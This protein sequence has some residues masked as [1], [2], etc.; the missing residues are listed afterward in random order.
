MTLLLTEV[1]TNRIYL[2]IA[3][4]FLAGF[5]IAILNKLGVVT[6]FFKKKVSIN[7]QQNL[8]AKAKSIES[9][10]DAVI[11]INYD[12]IIMAWNRG[13]EI[14]FGYKELDALNK[15]F[16]III[17]DRNK[18][19]FNEEFKKM[20]EGNSNMLGRNVETTVIG[21]EK[22]EFLVDILMWLWTDDN[23]VFYSALINNERIEEHEKNERKLKIY[24]IGEEIDNSGVWHW[25]VLSDN[26]YYSK[27]FLDI[28]DVEGMSSNSV[29]LLKKVYY[30]DRASVEEAIRKAFETKQP[31]EIQYRILTSNGKIKYLNCKAK[32]YLD[33]DGALQYI[34]GVIHEL[35]T[36]LHNY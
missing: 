1:I 22:T 12:G 15:P 35:R 36:E 7:D 2:I 31:Y 25:D 17:P 27:G 23:K 20:K 21:R 9:A 3:F 19:N 5:L 18:F 30:Q 34:S 29:T 8:L 13:A 14:M 10:P 4:I 28:F 32:T 16:T 11:S 24:A 26:V 6:N 33:E